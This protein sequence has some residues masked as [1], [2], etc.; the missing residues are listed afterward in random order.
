MQLLQEDFMKDLL[1]V[2]GLAGDNRPDIR[3]FE[4]TVLR[5]YLR[6]TVIQYTLKLNDSTEKRY[7]GFHRESDGK[8]ARAFAILKLLRSNG[9]DDSD[10]FRV[11]KPILYA[12][13]LS[14]LLLER[15]EGE[16]LNAIMEDH[17]VNSKPSVKAS[18]RWLSKLH[19]TKVSM[20]RFNSPSDQAALAQRY[21]EALVRIFP[22]YSKRIL[23]ITQ[24]L[25]QKRRQF[26]RTPARPI[27]GDYHP[28]NIIVSPTS[29]TAIDFEEACMGDPAYDLGYFI[30]QTRMTQ[31][32]RPQITR[33]MDAFLD[34]YTKLS[35]S[36]RNLRRRVKMHEAQTYLQR[37][38]HTYVLLHLKPDTKL[39]SEWL[40]QSERCLKDTG[41]A[42]QLQGRAGA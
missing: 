15:A 9:F 13:S 33:M 7:I 35:P 23:S 28:K 21:K 4:A 24:K 3:D 2:Q 42:L 37:I 39:V 8:F 10:E 29:V 31:G 5:R 1:S 12:P 30:A 32:L 18:A 36:D 38:Y 40:K 6:K 41:D 19:R 11:P 27:H 16:T 26:G 22:Q 34:E 20:S 17:K 14:L 25:A